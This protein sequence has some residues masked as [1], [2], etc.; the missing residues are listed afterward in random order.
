[1]FSLLGRMVP[2]WESS[3][4]AS[5]STTNKERVGA[6][7]RL[8][9]NTHQVQVRSLSE[10]WLCDLGQVLG[11]SAVTQAEQKAKPSRDHFF[12]PLQREGA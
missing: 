3:N 7:S 8:T 5:A 10:W 6:E 9:E 11:M 2:E 12:F 4:S 1:M